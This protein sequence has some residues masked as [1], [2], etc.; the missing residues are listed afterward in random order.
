MALRKLTVLDVTAGS[1]AQVHAFTF[2][3]SASFASMTSEN[4]RASSMLT[5]A[6]MLAET[7]AEKHKH[8]AL[9][10]QECKRLAELYAG[11]AEEA[12]AEV[13]E[14]AAAA[15]AIMQ[16][17]EELQIEETEVNREDAAAFLRPQQPTPAGRV[18]T[19]MH[20]LGWASTAGVT[21][22]AAAGQEIAA[23]GH[24]SE[25]DAGSGPIFGAAQAAA[26]PRHRHSH[27][28][29]HIFASPIQNTVPTAG[30][31]LPLLG[32]QTILGEAIEEAAP[33]I[34]LLPRSQ[35][36]FYSDSEA[37]MEELDFTSTSISAEPLLANRAVVPPS[38][39]SQA[40]GQVW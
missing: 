1:A 40:L 30:E 9:K 16:R 32:L 12:A 34:P 23:D 28:H 26:G 19:A 35:A 17:C 27:S 3:T 36:S 31:G 7:A 18:L 15:H 21:R 10:L 25:N 29:S 22:S 11:L 39:Q 14:A 37:D 13:E 24:S 4:A 6:R 33:L 8:A 5:H 38:V 2:S 20:G